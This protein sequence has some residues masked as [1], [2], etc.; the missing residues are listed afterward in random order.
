LKEKGRSSLLISWGGGVVKVLLVGSGGREHAI[1]AALCRSAEHVQLYAFMGS[2]N[3][4]IT[5]LVD[6]HK[7][8]FVIGDIRDADAVVK[9]ALSAG[10]DY[11][12]IGPEVVLEAGVVDKLEESGIRCASPLREAAR[13][14]TDKAF[15]RELMK[16]YNIPGVPRFGVFSNPEEAAKMIDELNGNVA[17][18]P[19]GLTSGKGVKVT[20]AQLKDGWEAKKYAREVIE[21]EIGGANAVVIEEKLDGEEFTL[22]A[23]V[24]G[25][26]V[27]G[28]PAVQDHKLAF[29]GDT[30]PNTGGM[31]SYSDTNHLLPFMQ[32]DDYAAGLSIMKG[33]VEAL[34]KEIGVNYKGVLY[35]QFMLTAKGPYLIEFNARFGDPEAMNVLTILESDYMKILEKIIDGTLSASDMRFE[36]SATVCKY[37]VPAGYPDA[38]K[39]NQPVLIDEWGIR[40]AGAHLYYGAVH[41]EEDGGAYTTGS[42]T[43]AVVGVSDS[44][45]EAEKVAEYAASFITGEVMHRKD[46]GTKELIQ[47]RIDHMKKIRGK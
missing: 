26:H 9:W 34:T 45:T 6:E 27:F 3:P 28:M 44:I 15:A 46:I 41:Q 39:K 19:A 30:G 7:G 4:G 20:G 33:A 1:A 11:A 43:A 23:F 36:R 47:K 38:P 22:Q 29:E 18:K 13:I 2:N 17:V 35:G 21:K 32:P 5:R 12:V 31:G 42:R 14:E 25:K 10:V 37:I 40:N 8:K 24:D 16:K